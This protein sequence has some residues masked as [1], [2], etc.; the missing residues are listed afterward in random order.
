MITE[1]CNTIHPFVESV[2]KEPHTIKKEE[3]HTQSTHEHTQV[4][5]YK[6]FALHLVNSSTMI[7]SG[8]DF[9]SVMIESLVP[10][11]EIFSILPFALSVQYKQ[12]CTLSNAS[13]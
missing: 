12:R 11:R 9:E 2:H 1:H 6:Y 5:K 13:P 7:S 8:F 10:L 4:K 3:K